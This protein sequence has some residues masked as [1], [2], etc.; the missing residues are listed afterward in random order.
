MADRVIHNRRVSPLRT[1]AMPTPA[2]FA[3]L[4]ASLL[5]RPATPTTVPNVFTGG[6]LGEMVVNV[7]AAAVGNDEL[8]WCENFPRE[9]VVC[10][11]YRADPDGR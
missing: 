6:L 7:E 8:A 1:S 3:D 11:N 9:G 2:A 5:A 10:V 4:R